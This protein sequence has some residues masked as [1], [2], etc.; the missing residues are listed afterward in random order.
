[1]N[2]ITIKYLVIGL[3]LAVLL[4]DAKEGVNMDT[5]QKVLKI[6]EQQSFKGS[7]KTF[8]GD[9]KVTI[10]FSKNITTEDAGAGFVEFSPKARS[11][12]HTHPKGQILLVTQGV[13]YT[14][15]WGKDIQIIK[16]GDTV[17]CPPNVKHWHGASHDTAMSHIAIT[18]EFNGNNVEWL[19][20]VSDEEYNKAQSKK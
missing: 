20:K 9:V 13:G 19:E 1:M 15:E 17:I 3:C 14:Q 6:E 18:G 8:S 11:A 4:L 2:L 5:N 12:W 10:L 16:A 7:D